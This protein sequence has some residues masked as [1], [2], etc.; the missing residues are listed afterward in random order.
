MYTISKKST[1]KL[2]KKVTYKTLSYLISSCQPWGLG[3]FGST[4]FDCYNY[5]T[6][7]FGWYHTKW[8]RC[9]KWHQSLKPSRSVVDEDVEPKVGWLWH[10]G[11]YTKPENPSNPLNPPNKKSKK[12]TKMQL[13]QPEYNFKPSN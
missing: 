10:L 2:F 1:I 12:S 8:K 4:D 6:L 5:F 7:A 9:Y 13:E 11:V 3:R